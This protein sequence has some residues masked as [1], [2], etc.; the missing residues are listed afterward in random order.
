MQHREHHRHQLPH[1]P[2]CWQAGAF[3]LISMLNWVWCQ[4]IALTQH[5]FAISQDAS[6]LTTIPAP[7]PLHPPTPLPLASM[8]VQVAGWVP[9]VIVRASLLRATCNWMALSSFETENPL[10]PSCRA[11]QTPTHTRAWP[12]VDLHHPDSARPA[13]LL[14]R[15]FP[16]LLL[17]TIVVCQC[18]HRVL[19]S[20][21]P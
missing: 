12:H 13:H 10:G 17:Q 19:R 5:T 11:L 7:C 18:E 6:L 4:V 14:C 16:L 21:P 9:S 15:R 8:Q 20:T 2:V 3:L 1:H